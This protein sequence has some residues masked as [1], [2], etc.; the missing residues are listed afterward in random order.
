MVEIIALP[1]QVAY[2]VETIGHPLPTLLLRLQSGARP[3]IIA[4]DGGSGAGKSTLAVQIAQ[5][6]NAALV[7][8]DDFY[9]AHIPDAE[10]DRRTPE[11]RYDDVIDWRRLRTEVL[12]PLRAGQ[13]ARWHPF[14]FAHPRADGTYPPS[15]EV[16]ERGPADVIVLDGAYST[17]PE[18]LD[19]IDLTMLIDVPVSI[20]HARLAA[21]EDAAFLTAWHARWDA[22]EAYYFSQV[23]P[24]AVFDLVIGADGTL[25]TLRT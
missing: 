23:R 8:S 19:L 5:V 16:V 21:R 20:R 12:L 6:L 1:S 22:V 18:L 11:E 4:I 3:F 7:Q 15:S 17:R 14:D 9:S 2:L 25:L 13:T 10:W 24:T